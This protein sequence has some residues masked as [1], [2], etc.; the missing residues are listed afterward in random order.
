MTQGQSGRDA[1]MALAVQRPLGKD[2]Y[3][4]R[5]AAVSTRLTA[6]VPATE[7]AERAS[8]TVDVLLKVYAKVLDDQRAESNDK[9]GGTGQ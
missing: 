7:V 5:H 3:D 1:F 4:R 9:I 6:G 8:H 2:P